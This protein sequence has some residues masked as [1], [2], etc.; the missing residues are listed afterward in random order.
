VCACFGLERCPEVVVLVCHL[1]QS[2][3]PSMFSNRKFANNDLA[4]SCRYGRTVRSVHVK[5]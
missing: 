1:T 5:T 3:P 2:A 4:V